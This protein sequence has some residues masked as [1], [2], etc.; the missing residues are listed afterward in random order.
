MTRSEKYTFSTF[1]SHPEE[2]A[3]LYYLNSGYGRFQ[4][5]DNLN[6]EKVVERLKEEIS[7]EVLTSEE[8]QDLINNFYKV[9]G[10]FTSINK[11]GK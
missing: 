2:A 11:D 5:L 7:H 4:N 8:K 3:I 10:R 6:D 9:R 1:E